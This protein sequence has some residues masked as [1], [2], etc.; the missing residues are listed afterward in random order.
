[1]ASSL[2]GSAS[3]LQMNSVFGGVIVFIQKHI[4][5]LLGVIIQISCIK[6][7]SLVLSD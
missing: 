1:M 6:A 7:K 3:D 2:L 5:F 4:A